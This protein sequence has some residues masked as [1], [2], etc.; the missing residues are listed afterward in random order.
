MVKDEPTIKDLLGNID[1]ALIQRLLER[2][3]GGDKS[4]FTVLTIDY[5]AV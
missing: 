4:A 5:L 1:K 2:K 3:Y